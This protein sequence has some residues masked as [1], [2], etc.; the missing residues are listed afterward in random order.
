MTYL[1]C[2]LDECLTGEY[3]ATQVCTKIT[4][5]LKLLYRKNRF[6]SKDLRRLLCNA[7]IQPHFDFAC[8][9]WYPNLNKKYK[10]KLK[11]LQNNCICFFLQ[12]DNREHIRTE[13]FDKINWVLIDQRFK[14]CLSTS[15]YKFFSEICPEHIN[16]IDKKFN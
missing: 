12:L 2:V 13:Y 14:H 8:A 10:N 7:L 1:G 5:K 15:I 3:M 16:I 6:L 4:S 9:A 11:V